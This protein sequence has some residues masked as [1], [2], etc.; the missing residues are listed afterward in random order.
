MS[1]A[2]RAV[3]GLR[4][5]RARLLIAA[6]ALVSAAGALFTSSGVAHADVLYNGIYRNWQ[7]GHCLDSNE[8][9]VAYS[10]AC[11]GGNYQ[12]WSI[13]HVE[14]QNGW[15]FGFNIIDDETHLCLDTNSSAVYTHSC[16]SGDPNQVWWMN[17]LD[18]EHH[19]WQNSAFPDKILWDNGDGSLGMSTSWSWSSDPSLP[20]CIPTS[21]L[22][23]WKPGF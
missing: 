10:I 7:S 1:S 12:N 6:V 9:G 20:Y 5:W 2:V 15:L 16:V 14:T 21:G 11:N 22:G 18:N 4:S 19:V 23:M 13:D 8:N 3:P 17:A